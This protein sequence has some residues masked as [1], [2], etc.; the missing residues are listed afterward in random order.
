MVAMAV[1]HAMQQ[2]DRLRPIGVTSGACKQDVRAP[3][4]ATGS[5]GRVP[6]R[7]ITPYLQIHACSITS[8][9]DPLCAV[10]QRLDQLG[11]QC[12]QE[13]QQGA[14]NQP[15]LLWGGKHTRHSEA[16]IP[17][18]RCQAQKSNLNGGR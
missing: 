12:G 5:A 18:V 10:L 7:H 17:E 2:S 8:H 13:G 3:G 6:C 1:A 4:S 11:I 15:K 9:S 14:H 16:H